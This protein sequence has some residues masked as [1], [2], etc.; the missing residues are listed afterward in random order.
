MLA[1]AARLRNAQEKEDDSPP[2]MKLDDGQD[3]EEIAALPIVVP[4]E[5]V[6]D[7]IF[8]AWQIEAAQVDRSV[9]ILPGVK[10]LMDSIP[11]GRCAVATSGAKT[12]GEK[13]QF[14]SNLTI[15][16]S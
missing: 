9:R 10:K 15:F 2:V 5:K 3:V 12:Y 13:P 14:L 11:D 16:F 6:R 4:A 1:I 7:V 8:E